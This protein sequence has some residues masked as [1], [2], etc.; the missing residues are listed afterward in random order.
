[1]ERYSPESR[2]EFLEWPERGE[3]W[4]FVHILTFKWAISDV[5][6]RLNLSS[7]DLESASAS[8]AWADTVSQQSASH[9]GADLHCRNHTIQG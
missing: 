2:C 7:P 4:P 3:A 8:L 1:M 6:K 9:D 5:T